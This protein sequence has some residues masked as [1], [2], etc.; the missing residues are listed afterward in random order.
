[1]F[2][3]ET[4]KK[5]K[6]VMIFGTNYKSLIELDIFMSCSDEFSIMYGFGYN[7]ENMHA[8]VSFLRTI[9]FQVDGEYFY[10]QMIAGT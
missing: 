3:M 2:P 1:M 6:I 7:L 8:Q 4:Y 10:N 9:Q 5:V